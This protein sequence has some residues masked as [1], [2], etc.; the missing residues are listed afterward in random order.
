MQH[1]CEY[2]GVFEGAEMLGAHPNGRSFLSDCILSDSEK[3]VSISC[4][5]E[6]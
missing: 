5:S 6:L 1:K 4:T 2:Q 3:E